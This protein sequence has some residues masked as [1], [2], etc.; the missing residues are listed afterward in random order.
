[1][2]YFIWNLVHE[3]FEAPKTFWTLLAASLLTIIG[4]T[5][6]TIVYTCLGLAPLVNLIV[7]TVL[8]IMWSPGFGFLWYYSTGT[9]SHVCNKANWTGPTGIMVCRVYKALFAFS[10]L[11]FFM[12]LG[13]VLLDVI[14][15]RRT[16][17]RG[18]YKQ[19]LDPD[20]PKG[21]APG[22]A[23]Y[24]APQY[25]DSRNSISLSGYTQG[26]QQ[27]G[28]REGYEMPEEQFNYDTSYRGGHEPNEAQNTKSGVVG[29]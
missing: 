14:I 25:S 4:L 8:F 1:M 5:G 2:F 6:T 28:D 10:M 24:V 16:T 18:K 27:R 12:T 17:S 7:N 23:P 19:M 11:G 20:Q 13:A 9:L 22:S 15:W 21:I 3:D 29:A 26:Q